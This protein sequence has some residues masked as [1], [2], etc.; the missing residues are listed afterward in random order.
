MEELHQML[1]VKDPDYYAVVDK[2]NPVRLIRALEVCIQTGQSFSSLRREQEKKRP[3]RIQKYCLWLP[4]KQLYERIDR[5]VDQMMEQG[6][7]EEAKKLY[8]LKHLNALNTV[9]YKELFAYIEGK[10]S[11]EEAIWQIKN[12]THHYA[13]RQLTWFKRD[14]E[15]QFLSPE[16]AAKLVPTPE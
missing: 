2:R 10:N 13:K 5:R 4:K 6:L 11:L 8:P 12:N 3:F 16:E 14:K 1:K 9:G 7:L 15:Y